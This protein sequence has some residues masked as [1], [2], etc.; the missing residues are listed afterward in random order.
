VQVLLRSRVLLWLALWVQWLRV[1]VL[2]LYWLAH[3]P[4]PALAR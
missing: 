1:V 3:L 4:P 2:R